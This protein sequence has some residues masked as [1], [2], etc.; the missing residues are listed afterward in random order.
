MT[1]EHAEIIVEI[2]RIL[3]RE[4]LISREERIRLMELLRKE[5]CQDNVQG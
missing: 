2:S 3:E 1:Q 4:A 5:S